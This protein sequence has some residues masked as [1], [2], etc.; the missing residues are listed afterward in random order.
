MHAARSKGKFIFGYR[1]K[2]GKVYT[3]QELSLSLIFTVQAQLKSPNSSMGASL[4]SGWG[5]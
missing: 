5:S 4:G 1:N 2:T 3:F